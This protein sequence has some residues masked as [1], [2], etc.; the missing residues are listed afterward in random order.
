MPTVNTRTIDHIVHLTPPGS[1][2]EVS[3]QFNELGFVVLKGGTHADGLTGNALVLLGDGTYLELISF[4]HPP[5]HYP[6]N[7]PERS[8]RDQHRWSRKSPGWIDY[9][10]LGNGVRDPSISE[11]I[12]KRAEQDGS[13]I[14]Y[15]PEVD[16]GRVRPD[17]KVLKWLIS[18]AEGEDHIGVVPFFCGDVT[19]RELRVPSDSSNTRHP[20]T[21]TGLAFIRLVASKESFTDV[22]KQ[23]TTVLVGN[24]P[25]S[26]NDTQSIWELDTPGKP[27]FAPKRPS[28][29][30]EVPTT[31]KEGSFLASLEG[32]KQGIYEVGFYV[33]A[34]GDRPAE[35]QT[36]Y[37]KIK[38][39]PL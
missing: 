39:I 32:D 9:A 17:G 25:L 14:K 15:L 21:V 4:T 23:L 30:V 5:S 38:F 24:P 26:T 2:E 31:E 10:F 16:G 34:L 33:Q 18:A 8:K 22:V 28:L 19:P 1:V 29:I 35:T 7:S 12:N 27:G 3:R 13:G 11:T 20:S 36:P 37:G 6:G